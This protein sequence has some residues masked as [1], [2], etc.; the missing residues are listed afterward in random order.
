MGT[1]GTGWNASNMIGQLF[2]FYKTCCQNLALHSVSFACF[3]WRQDRPGNYLLLGQTPT[4]L[5]AV[6][7]SCISVQLWDKII[8]APPEAFFALIR[9]GQ[10][11]FSLTQLN[12]LW[13]TL[14]YLSGHYNW[15]LG[16][17]ASIDLAFQ[18]WPAFKAIPFSLLVQKC[19]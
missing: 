10:G 18:L 12:F 19:K 4:P 8:A 6:S 9:V 14:N 3:G 5:R 13:T 1:Q 2:F 7:L 11:W 17:P 16:P 15:N